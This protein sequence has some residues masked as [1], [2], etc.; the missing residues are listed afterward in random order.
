[1]NFYNFW[2][3]LVPA[4]GYIVHGKISNSLLQSSSNEYFFK[5]K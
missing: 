4:K 3:L 5:D 1:M 2:F